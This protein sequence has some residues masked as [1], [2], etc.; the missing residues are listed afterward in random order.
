MCWKT[1]EKQWE[2]TFRGH[3][4][5]YFLFDALFGFAFTSGDRVLLVLENLLGFHKERGNC[6]EVQITPFFAGRLLHV[7]RHP[8][9]HG[10]VGRNDAIGCIW[11]DVKVG[12]FLMEL[13]FQGN[14]MPVL[15]LHR[16]LLMLL[17]PGRAMSTPVTS[18]PEEIHDFENLENFQ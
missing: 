8:I 16:Q 12:L 6:Q 15:R 14:E 5:W 10:N 2:L 3:M 1:S 4:F 7:T 9:G 17:T 18:W 11:T 13:L